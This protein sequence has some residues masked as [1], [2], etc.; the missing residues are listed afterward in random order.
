MK[1]D[2]IRPAPKVSLPAL[3]LLLSC[4]PKPP[5]PPPAPAA[6]PE[7]QLSYAARSAYLQARVAWDR[8][9]PDEAE[10]LL[11]RAVLFD[12]QSAWLRG[13]LA[14]LYVELDRPEDALEAADRALALDPED[15]RAMAAWEQVHY[16]QQDPPGE[17]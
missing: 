16:Q 12:P 3:L 11:R 7:P 10:R 1:D 13:E 14:L 15:P 17:E 5:P 2:L 9:A 8:G 4:A 6:P